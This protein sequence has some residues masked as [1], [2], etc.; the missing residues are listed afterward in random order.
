MAE[1]LA[2][3]AV[4]GEE[5]DA[6]VPHKLVRRFRGSFMIVNSIEEI[7]GRFDIRNRLAKGLGFGALELFVG[8]Q[9][10]IVVGLSDKGV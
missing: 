9:A 10:V 7:K 1:K 4:E 8:D 2:E 6:G 3:K 5:L